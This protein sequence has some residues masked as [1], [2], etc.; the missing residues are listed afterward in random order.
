MQTGTSLSSKETLSSPSSVEKKELI[1]IIRKYV[2]D[3]A[4]QYGDDGVSYILVKDRL[5][6]TH[7]S[8]LVREFK[9]LIQREIEHYIDSSQRPPITSCPHPPS[10]SMPLAQTPHNRT[11]N[12]RKS[13][14]LRRYSSSSTDIVEADI[15]LIPYRLFL[16]ESYRKHCDQC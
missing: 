3:I 12:V 1:G 15:V 14:Y 10:T 16:H 5:I 11:E 13:A 2:H 8:E 4:S 9:Y 6:Q 7:G